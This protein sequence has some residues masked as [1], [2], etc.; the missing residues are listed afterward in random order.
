MFGIETA[1]VAIVI[2][3][4]AL[5][6]SAGALI[7]GGLTF[8]QN[9][10]R[11]NPRLFVRFSV[12]GLRELTLVDSISVSGFIFGSMG[13]VNRGNKPVMIDGLVAVLV[14]LNPN[15]AVAK[16]RLTTWPI[17]ENDRKLLAIYEQSRHTGASFRADPDVTREDI[18]DLYIK[19]GEREN[20]NWKAPICFNIENQAPLEAG[21]DFLWAL[22][23]MLFDARNNVVMKTVPGAIIHYKGPLPDGVIDTTCFTIGSPLRPQT[24]L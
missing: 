15:D 16:S 22:R 1:R 6:V 24:V 7:L 18:R 21:S 14:K 4:I 17:L 23:I 9:F 13:L 2:S 12:R 3:I 10:V 11:F 19:S 20:L 8:Y 5:L